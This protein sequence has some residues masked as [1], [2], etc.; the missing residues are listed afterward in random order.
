MVTTHVLDTT[1]GKPATDI[2]VRLESFDGGQW[3]AVADA[4]TDADGRV[5]DLGPQQV[6]AG[7]YRLTFD[8]G[9]YFARSGVSTFYRQVQICFSIDSV[10][11]HYHVP[12][13][14][15]PWAYSTYRGS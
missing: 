13:L 1:A 9:E 7:E 11:Q 8:T 4:R 14:V 10:D 6:D 15:S 3:V 2:A 12:L 5:S